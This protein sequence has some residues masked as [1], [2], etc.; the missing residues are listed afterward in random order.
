[1]FFKNKEEVNSK[2]KFAVI[3]S[4]FLVFYF[5]TIGSGT[6]QN[7]VMES[8]F[9]MQE[10]ARLHVLLCLVPAFFIAGA[11]GNFISQGAVLKYLGAKANKVLAYGVASV[12]GAILAVCSCT[13]FPLF[14]SIYKRGAGL[15]PAIAFLYSDPA[16][17]LPSMRA[18]R[19]MIGTKKTVV[20]V[21]LVIIMS[22]I[23]GM[24]YGAFA[25]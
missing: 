4:V 1:M 21:S 25:G 18:I 22:T 23:T 24:V 12:S 17:S 13:V 19:S 3:L 16:I 2:I 11:I 7:A 9:M 5:V 20:Y 14:G 6:V 10:Y 15:G 8:L